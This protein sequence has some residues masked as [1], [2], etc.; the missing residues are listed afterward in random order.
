[1]AKAKVTKKVAAPVHTKRAGSKFNVE[2]KNASQKLAWIEFQRHD[3]VFLTGPAGV[4]KTHLAM[5][6]AI[7]EVLEKKKKKIVLTRPIVEA[8]ESLGFL[9]GEFEDK[10]HPYMLPCLDIVDKMTGGNLAAKE[11]ISKAIELA[12]V[13]YMRG[14]ALLDSENIITPDGLKPIGEMEVGDYVIGKN[15]EPTQVLAVYPQGEVPIFEI[16]FS[17]HTKSI[18]CGE[19]LWSTM[20]LNEKRH[21][22]GYTTKNTLEIMESVKNKHNQKVHRI[23][24]CDSVEFNHRDVEINPYF[25][26]FLLGDGSLHKDASISISTRDVEV[27]E[28]ISTSLP[29][30]LEI[31]YASGYDYRIVKTDSSKLLN[32]LKLNL[33]KLNLIGKKSH[34]KF[35]PN[36]YKFN[37]KEVR[38]EILRGLMDADGWICQ[39]KSGNCRIQYSTTS[40]KLCEDVKF[41]VRSLG[42]LAYSRTREYDE[43]DTHEYKGRPIR[44]VHNSYVVDMMIDV[45]P[46]KL[47]RKAEKYSNGQNP[48]PVKMISSIKEIGKG[49]CTC[50]KV[51][52]EDSLFLTEDFI[53]THN[54]FDD[55]ICIFDEAQNAT[56][57]Q[58]KLFLTRFG[59]SSK[60]ILTGDPKQ[61]DLPHDVALVEVME[62]LQ[63]LRGVGAVMFGRNAIVRHPL[64][65]DILQRLEGDE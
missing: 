55:S 12:P 36:E 62:K 63:T 28:E 22:K 40:E 44:H 14:R 37:S 8:G 61:T 64:I 54:T 32:P 25:L 46:F 56:M 13:A 58:L 20:T 47:S 38:I 30:T 5:A 21:N 19:H 11:I 6:F 34:D 23:P 53:V 26:G 1:M 48:K 7:S 51:D 65:A 24:I 16:E 35:V 42:G 57:T 15:G 50:I 17:D 9:P 29:E 33:N 3:I 43:S 2:W 27:I 39:H 45:N 59:D 60:L 49:G 10:V 18:C 41:L 4:G 52:A 31:K